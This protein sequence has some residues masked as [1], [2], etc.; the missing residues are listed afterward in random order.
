MGP[1]AAVVGQGQVRGGKG[2]DRSPGQPCL[3]GP[4]EQLVIAHKEKNK[5]MGVNRKMMRCLLCYTEGGADFKIL[6]PPPVSL[7][8]GAIRSFV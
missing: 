4:T 5:L 7:C 8:P 3:S 1:S 6:D 2:K